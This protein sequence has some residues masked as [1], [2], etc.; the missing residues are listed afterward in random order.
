MA[1]GQHEHAIEDVIGLNPKL[2]NMSQELLDNEVSI[3][4]LKKSLT[5]QIESLKSQITKLEEQLAVTDPVVPVPDPD[6]V[7]P[8]SW[9]P[10]FAGDVKPGNIRWGCSHQSNG[11]PTSHETA[12]AK[13]VGLR[14][15]FWRMSKTSGLLS[16]VKADHTAGRVPWVSVKLETSWKNVAA[17]TIDT[18]LTKLFNDLKATGK[19]VWFTA[20]HEPEG[21]NGTPY[22]DDGQGTEPDWRAMQKHVRKLIDATGA[23]NIAFAP[24]L[25]AWTFDKRSGRNPADWWVDGIWDFA[26]IDHYIDEKATTMISP[27]WKN[28]LEFYTTKGLQIAIG[29]WGNKDHGVSGAAEMQEWYDHLRS[30]KVLGA[31]YFDTNLNGGVPL[32]GDVLI[33]FRELI[34]LNT[35]INID[36]G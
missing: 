2:D 19:T 27:M 14:R 9:V 32:S 33:K 22:P 26:G 36:E 30:V 28:T 35:S 25:M 24:I 12:A 3:G 5:T 6:P 8:P 20:H 16:T 4:D 18:A 23:K 15:T 10:K 34:K 31:C 7:V 17:G 21:G 1:G 11:V 29:E 13:A